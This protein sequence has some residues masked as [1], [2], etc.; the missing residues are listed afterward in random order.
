MK[1]RNGGWDGVN[2]PHK[3]NSLVSLK[4]TDNIIRLG[5]IKFIC[6]RPVWE[7]RIGEHNIV[8][9]IWCNLFFEIIEFFP[10]DYLVL[11][12]IC[13]RV[14]KAKQFELISLCFSL[15]SVFQQIVC[16]F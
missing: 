11:H 12:N 5:I 3:I 13:I 15:V 9:L 7:K 6:K 8:E 2:N 14:S 16:Y 10:V 4:G 1:R